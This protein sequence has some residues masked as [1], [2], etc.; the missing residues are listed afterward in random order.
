MKNLLIYFGIFAMFA[1]FF[2]SCRQDPPID[3]AMLVGKWQSGNN[4]YRYNAN[5]TGV[6]WNPSD[7]V[8]E[9][10]GRRFNWTLKGSELELVFI[11][12]LTGEPLV[13]ELYTVTALTTTTLSLRDDMGRVTSFTRIE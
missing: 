7:D 13:W 1:L 3:E 9:H 10:E 11:S 6:T 5:R 4:F 8:Y 2:A 12:D